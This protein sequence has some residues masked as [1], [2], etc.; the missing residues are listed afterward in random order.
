MQKMMEKLVT[1]NIRDKTLGYVPYI[2]NNLPTNQVSPQKPQCIVWHVYR[3][4]WKR[5]SNTS[6]FLDIEGASKNTSSDITNT[7]KWHGVGDTLKWWIGS[8]L[9]GKKITAT[10]RRNTGGVCGQVLSIAR[11][12]I[13]P[14]LWSLVVDRLIEGTAIIQWMCAILNTIKFTNTVSELLQEAFSMEK[15]GVLKL[16]YP[17]TKGSASGSISYKYRSPRQNLL[18]EHWTVFKGWGC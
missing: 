9:G 3:K 18:A 12:F 16:R 13:T 14:Q 10:H 6:A 15:S 7:A 4:Q 8:M 1:R 5:G 17:P 11:H 2:P